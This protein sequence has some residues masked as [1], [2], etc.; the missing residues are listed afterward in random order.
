MTLR[1]GRRRAITDFNVPRDRWGRPMLHPPEGGERVPYTRI[2]TM[3]KWLDSKEGLV[4]WTAAQAMIGLNKSKSLQARISSLVAKSE[5]DPYAENKTALKELV[6]TA[7]NLAQAQARADFGTAVHEF[8]ELLD[9]GT[10]DWSYV[11]DAL[12]GPLDAYKACMESLKVLDT[13]VF[14]T[15]D[16]Q[17]GGQVV[18]GAGSL[19][20]LVHHPELGVVVGDVKT[21]AQEPKY[22][23]GVTTQV[24]AYAHGQRY[25][26]ADF[27]G[28]PIFNDGQPNVDVS[29]WRK[30]LHVQ[31]NTETGLLIHLPLDPIRGKYVCH[32]Y[33]LDLVKGWECLQLG[34][35]VQASKKMPKL[36]RL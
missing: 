2:S 29:A 8:T 28:S 13:E 27:K 9:A 15:V 10:L 19:D 14:I 12:K 23:L 11:P 35:Q 20:R 4:N 34:S 1:Y 31:I 22:P 25:R 24:A 21:G 30:A 17:M 18:R 26:D 7:T 3:A 33:V 32:L 36:E 16:H 5:K 6:S